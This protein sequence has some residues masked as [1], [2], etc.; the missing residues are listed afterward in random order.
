MSI[1]AARQ[2]ISVL[3]G[4]VHLAVRLFPYSH[5]RS[6]QGLRVPDARCPT[7]CFGQH[8]KKR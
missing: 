2:G 7:P 8:E 3:T 1:Y 4:P 5:K 6:W